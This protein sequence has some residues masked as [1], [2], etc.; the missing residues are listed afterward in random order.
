MENNMKFSKV[1]LIADIM[2]LIA[3]EKEVDSEIQKFITELE[4]FN[5]TQLIDL[6]RSMKKE[7][8]GKE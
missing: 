2:E 7:K 8:L 1:K 5:E 6:F 3:T 4:Y